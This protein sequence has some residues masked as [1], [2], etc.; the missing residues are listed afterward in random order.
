MLAVCAALLAVSGS[1][2]AATVS[3][4]Y[5]RGYTVLPSPQRV[6]LG[7]HDFR[8][9]RAWRLEL[10]PGVPADDVAVETL[11]DELAS[12][13][14][15]TLNPGDAQR[16]SGR[17]LRLAVVPRSVAVPVT[18]AADHD[19]SALAEQAYRISL[20]PNQVAITANALPGLFYGVDTFIQLLKPQGD[21]LLLPE[22]E[23]EDWPNLELRVIY[24][25]NAHHLDHLDVLKAA[26][27]QAAFY[28]INGFAIKLEG[29]FQYQHAA[30][31][32]EPYAMTPAELQ[33]LTNYALKYHIQL[34]PYLDGPAHVAF[35]LKHPEYAGLREFP[36][37]NYEFCS[38]N[39]DTYKL[40]DGMYQDLLDANRGGKYFVLSTDE[41]YYVGLAKNAQCNEVDAAHQ[42][43][44]VG[45]VLAEFVTKAA[46]FLHDRGRTVIFWGEY[47]LKPSDISSLPSYL[48][49]GELY[50]PEFDPVFK[51][52]G[53]RQM[54]Y[55]STEGEEPLF[56]NYYLLP[57][58]DLLH[59]R[60]Q[61][62]GRVEE[63]VDSITQSSLEPVSSTE[64]AHPQANQ[65]DLMGAFI[66]GW[67]DAGLHPEAFWLGYATAP[68]AAWNPTA[69]GADELMNSFY[70][71]FYGPG[72]VNMAHLYQLMS[73]QAEFWDDSWQRVPSAARSPIWG[74]SYGIF[75]P[76]RP[77]DDQTLP[78]LPVPSS[79]LLQLGYDWKPQNVRRL[80]LAA[81]FLH[82][83]D[84]LIDLLHANIERVEFNRYNLEVFLSVARL[85]RQNLRMILSLGQIDD[86]LK[87]AAGAAGRAQSAEA[88]TTL[89]EAL[90]LAESIRQERN[91]ALH[92]AT[93][94]WYKTWF[95]RVAEANGRHYLNEVDN[96][97]D[98]VPVRT[99]DMSYLVYR[100]LL[101]PLGD[102]FR[103]TAEARNRYAQAHDLPARQRQ[104]EWKRY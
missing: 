7:E 3:P 64:A 85:Y 100:E 86:R 22:A 5:E 37:S 46:G 56:P 36:D 42:L 61:S 8:F 94:T 70:R 9:G 91:V 99:I 76:P 14:H 98:H 25:D 69:T 75:N 66:A 95:P 93:A 1:A 52:H 81:R 80:R 35:I 71:L 15:V 6:T 65:A 87:S 34:I 68:A 43:G 79:A 12:R 49:N 51:A 59:P 78:E 2:R 67:A 72:A 17:T 41:P 53:I 60:R 104:F 84:E 82:S 13:F 20:A 63:M 47:P 44:S 30:P 48:V 73:E 24:W 16:P 90:D 27:R 38:T 74:N 55:T 23:I 77:A 28:K 19:A 57:D 29:H 101:Y 45:K 50:G 88:V 62:T 11:K 32:V 96:V 31:I 97:K 92:D 102:W 26:L 40:L 39:P 58:S 89:D 4:L 103:K 21:T 10:L 54:I 83:N 33:D 18:G